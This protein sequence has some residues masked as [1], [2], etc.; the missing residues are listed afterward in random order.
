MAAYTVPS[1]PRIRELVSSGV[2][3][4]GVHITRDG[5][6]T[7]ARCTQPHPKLGI[8]SHTSYSL[9]EIEALLVKIQAPIPQNHRIDVMGTSRFPGASLGF[10]DF[11]DA[12][13]H[14]KRVSETYKGGV[15]NTLPKGSLTAVDVLGTPS[16]LFG[17]ACLVTESCGTHTFVSRIASRPKILGRHGV[18]NLT[19]WWAVAS[20]SQRLLLLSRAKHL[21]QD[22]VLGNG[23]L[24]IYP[25]WV[26]ALENL[27]CPFRDA[28]AQVGQPEEETSEEE[29]PFGSSSAD[30]PPKAER[31]VRLTQLTE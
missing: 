5:I 26:K 31:G 21:P 20:P 11:Q 27:P 23:A 18:N 10:S 16:D 3:T 9:D 13:S 30:L 4:I 14:G 12:V 6:D 2:I 24:H 7:W 15:K 25:E 1:S 19:E 22:I 17:R 28:E 8:A 29:E